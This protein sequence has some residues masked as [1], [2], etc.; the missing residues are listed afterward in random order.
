MTVQSSIAR[1]DYRGNGAT[2][3]FPVPFYFLDSTHIKVLRT[4]TSTAPPTTATLVLNSDYTVS[5]AGVAQG[6]SIQTTVAPTPTQTIIILRNVPFTQLVHYVPNDPFPAATHEQALD[7]LT[8]EVQEL[9]EEIGHSIQLPIYENAPAVVP[10]AASRAGTIIAFD[11]NGNLTYPPIPPSVGAGDIRNETWTAGTDFT[12]GTSTQVTLSRTYSNK[13]NLGTVVMDGLA[14]DP[15]TYALD[16]TG[17]KLK[18]TDT[19]G[20]SIVIPA[21]V[22]RIWCYGGTTL[23]IYNPPPGS[24]NAPQIQQTSTGRLYAQD[25]AQINRVND[26]MFIGDATVNDARYPTQSPDWLSTLQSSTFGPDGGAVPFAQLAVLTNAAA[27]SAIAA[28]AQTK[29]FTSA[30]SAAIGIQSFGYANNGAHAAVA[31]GYYGEAHRLNVGDGSAYGIEIAVINRG[32]VSVQQDPYSGPLG[33]STGIQIDSGNSFGVAQQPGLAAASSA[34]TVVQNTN[35]NSAPFLRGVVF[36]ANSIALNGSG[37]L[38]EALSMPKNYGLQWYGAAGTPTSAIYSTGTSSAA[39]MLLI[40]QDNSV[41]I[42]SASQKNV[43]TFDAVANAVNNFT[44]LPSVT[45]SPPVLAA[46]GADTNINILLQPKGAGAVQFGTYT[47][48][49]LSPAGY[50]SIVDAGGTPRRLLVG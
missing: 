5:G 10:P 6:G 33:L 13:A 19:N 42:A 38:S 34:M 29:Y 44:L 50:V 46:T 43:V 47:A 39:G 31:W 24:V 21:N 30:G 49:S 48:G 45:G 4:D 17:S 26:R 23:S 3:L 25:G 35:D 16:A 15:R 11:A 7:Q 36:S 27:G 40:M 14:Q 12:A 28:G 37:L 9:G 8:M 22:G 20:N 32:G 1:A 2:T 18:F 41:S